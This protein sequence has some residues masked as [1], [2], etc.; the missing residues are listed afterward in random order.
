VD[1]DA[2]RGQFHWPCFE[3]IAQILNIV[4][5]IQQSGGGIADFVLPE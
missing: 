1:P 4:F 2:L 5:P 3:I